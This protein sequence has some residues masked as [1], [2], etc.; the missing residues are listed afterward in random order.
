M[1][2]FPRRFATPAV[3][4]GLLLLAFVAD[5]KPAAQP[6]DRALRRSPTKGA[7]TQHVIISVQPG[8]GDYVRDSLRA[9][10]DTIASEHPLIDA[11]GG[12]IHRDDIDELT[13]QSCVKAVSME[14]IF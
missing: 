11:L 9:H 10:G 7:A 12:E 5:A 3:I 6:V 1:I 4:F 2:R 8:C 14:G 13:R